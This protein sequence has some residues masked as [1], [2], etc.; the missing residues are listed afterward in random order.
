MIQGRRGREVGD[1]LGEV[2]ERI[3]LPGDQLGH[4][5]HQAVQ[6]EIPEQFPGHGRGAELQKAENT[7]GF[8]DT[9]DLLEAGMAV[10][11]VS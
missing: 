4:K 7:A 9:G 6:I 10:G 3:A 11:K 1:A 2:A 8:E 5:G